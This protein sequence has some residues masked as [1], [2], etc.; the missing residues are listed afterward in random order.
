MTTNKFTLNN[1]FDANAKVYQTRPVRATKYK[2]GMESGF[3][4]YFS[5][6]QKNENEMLHEG[7]KFFAT[8]NEAWDF[9]RKN[10]KQYA[11]ENGVLLEFEAEYDTPRAVL[12]R[13]EPDIDKKV[14]F[15]IGHEGD[16]AF[17]SDE[18]D[19]YDFFI[20]SNDYGESEAWII[21]DADGNIRVWYE[22]CFDVFEDETFFGK[23]QDIIYEIAN[24]EYIKV[25]V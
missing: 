5:N 6:K 23:K 8:E 18:S 7:M 14:G 17:I 22:E 1:V 19:Q 16:C 11:K 10:N 2:P 13:K 9:I 3:M 25:A 12:H 21:Q 24:G 20:L 4:V 15:I